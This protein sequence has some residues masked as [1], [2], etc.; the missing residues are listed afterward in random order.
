[1][2]TKPRTFGL[3]RMAGLVGILMLACT[4]A[5]PSEAPGLP[6]ATP[7]DASTAQPAA[8]S[9]TGTEVS[10]YDSNGQMS[11]VFS[12]FGLTTADTLKALNE[13]RAQGD[14]SM[15]PVLVESMRF[16]GSQRARDATADV[17]EDL[18]GQ[19]FEGEPWLDWS[20]WLGRNREA[21]PPP[22][23]YMAWKIRIMSQIDPRFARFLRPA[24]IGQISVDPTELVWGGVI[25][26]GIP[27][28]RSP[29]MLPPEEADY[30]EPRERVFG[31]SIN[32][33]HRAYPL[34]ITNAHE[35]VNDTVGGEPIS[36]SW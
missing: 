24:T 1:M 31:I 9:P 11:K 32:G 23:E 20:N 6:G 36:L 22:S 7:T 29:K 28:L 15:V 13:V 12:G 21:Y 19:A 5:A 18:T 14:R 35:M 2:F 34:R 10:S 30:L 26:D 16:Q 4:S 27:D 17:L 8:P 25:P 3:P 33:D